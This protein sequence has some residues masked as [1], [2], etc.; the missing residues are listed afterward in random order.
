LLCAGFAFWTYYIN[1]Q[2]FIW[3]SVFFT[4]VAFL[5]L[6]SIYGMFINREIPPET[7]GA[8]PPSA[9]PLKSET[10]S[11]QVATAVALAA[12][13]VLDERYN[14]NGQIGVAYR[15]LGAMREGR[16]E[17]GLA[18]ADKNWQLCRI[19]AWLWNNRKLFRS[20][21]A[22]L[23]RLATSLIESHEPQ[24]IWDGFIATEA[25]ISWGRGVQSTLR[26]GERPVVGADSL[27]TMT[28]LYWLLSVKRVATL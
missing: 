1:R 24:D 19:Q 5:F 7:S 14:D 8:L 2:G 13:D 15:F 22:E 17:E 21:V 3:Y 11:E 10:A 18:L 28:W 20:D 27:E 6:V 9:T 12:N 4:I 16:V 23:Q 25:R 26:S